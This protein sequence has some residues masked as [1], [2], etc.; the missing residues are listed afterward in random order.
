MRFLTN[1]LKGREPLLID[2][3][4]AAEHAA[5]ADKFGFT[6]LLA[7]LFGEAPKAYIVERE[8]GSKVG[9]VPLRGIIGK[10]LGPLEKMAGAV[11]VDDV[12]ANIDAVL[13]QGADRIAFDVNSPGGTVTGVEELANKIRR[14]NVP[15]MAYTDTTMASAA[16]WISSAADRVLVSPSSDVGSIGVYS[17]YYDV[18]K[19]YEAEGIVP[20]V[21]K[22]GKHKAIGVE[23]APIT[24]EQDAYLQEQVEEIWEDFKAG[25]KM[26]RKLVAA[27]DME[28]QVYSGK[29]AARKGLATGIAESFAEALAKF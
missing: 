28:A 7:K 5:L 2:P 19:A 10:A 13:D 17:V 29:V 15:T 4:V 27:E 26:K 16:Y 11:D 9:V 23:G 18:S 3:A 20:H 21:Y 14:L 12:S 25:V 22:A 6:D 8:D 1:G 24:A